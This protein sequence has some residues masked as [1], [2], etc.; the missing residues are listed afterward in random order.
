[1]SNGVNGIKGRLWFMTLSSFYLVQSVAI[2]YM[3]GLLLGIQKKLLQLWFTPEFA[4]EPFSVC[5]D[6]TILEKRLL[7]V[8]PPSAIDRVPRNVSDSLKYWKASKFR[9]FLLFM[10]SSATL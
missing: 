1:M 10:L 2:D 6:V 5:K 8:S 3:H 7:A 9:S 4:K